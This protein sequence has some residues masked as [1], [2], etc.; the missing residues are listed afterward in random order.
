M[1][2]HRSADSKPVAAL[3]NLGPKSA[4]MLAEAG[5]STIAELRQLGAVRAY[6][7]VKQLHPKFASLN[8]LWALVAGLEDR[9][10][11]ELTKSE[12]DRLVAQ[13]AGRR[14]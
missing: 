1:P 2:P 7:R 3:R 11:R 5:V 6:L 14:R 8:L 12:K 9:D 10:W 13:V 4:M